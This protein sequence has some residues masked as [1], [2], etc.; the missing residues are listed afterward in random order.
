MGLFVHRTESRLVRVEVLY[1]I[2][3]DFVLSAGYETNL[4]T[5]APVCLYCWSSLKTKIVLN[6]SC[7][8]LHTRALSRRVFWE[9]GSKQRFTLSEEP[10]IHVPHR[11]YSNPGPKQQC[12]NSEATAVSNTEAVVSQVR[13]NSSV[14]TPKQQHV[15]HRRKGKTNTKAAPRRA[16]TVAVTQKKQQSH[17]AI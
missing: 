4:E 9:A 14:Q 6:V 5:F 2:S 17:D 13:S 3:L 8:G 11:S 15:Q 16:T 12:P 7:S 10:H 1:L